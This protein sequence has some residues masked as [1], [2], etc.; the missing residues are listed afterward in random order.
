[1]GIA[2]AKPKVTPISPKRFRHRPSDCA[3][4]YGGHV[5]GQAP[6]GFSILMIYPLVIYHT[7]L[8]DIGRSQYENRSPAAILSRPA[9]IL[10][11]FL[12]RKNF[13]PYK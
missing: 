13:L 3:Q 5:E 12:S 9:P 8:D 10:W 7:S 6:P 1:M 4:G 11:L 2:R